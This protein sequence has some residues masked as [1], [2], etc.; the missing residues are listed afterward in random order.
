MSSTKNLIHSGSVSL[1]L[2]LLSIVVQ[3]VSITVLARILTPEEYGLAAVA[4][5]LP[6]LFV[7]I[8]DMGFS[9][10]IV[11]KDI[12]DDA[13]ISTLFWTGL[14][15]GFLL[16][17]TAA[18]VAWWIADI[19]KNE[20]LYELTLVLSLSGLLTAAVMPQRAL[21]AREMGFISLS[22]V[23]FISNVVAVVGAT[24][25]AYSGAGVW[26]LVFLTMAPLAVQIPAWVWL[27]PWKPVMQ[28]KLAALIDGLSFGGRLSIIAMMSYLI[29]AAPAFFLGKWWG[30]HEAGLFSRAYNL[31]FVPI[32]VLT[33]QLT[34]M[35]FSILPRLNNDSEQFIQKYQDGSRLLALLCLPILSVALVTAPGLIFI[36][37]G[38]QWHEV[39]A[40]FRIL[41]VLLFFNPFAASFSWIFIPRAAMAELFKVTWW[42]W[43][44]TMVL[45][46]AGLLLHPHGVAWGVSVAALLALA[47]LA[48]AA[49]QQVDIA[50]IEMWI[51][52]RSYL[53]AALLSIFVGLVLWPY[54][55]RLGLL[56]ATAFT[57][58][59]QLFVYTGCVLS[60]SESRAFILL[61]ARKLVAKYQTKLS[62]LE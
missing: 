14:L 3:L 49:W 19:F 56:W 35:M 59:S 39:E 25:L 21:L 55:T 58:I 20:Q 26:A 40:Y 1:L 32:S 60:F 13:M 47:P 29:Q 24:I 5:A 45:A 44:G 23:G 8:T 34:L 46:G 17:G 36:I 22:L 37:L 28:F 7:L 61:V 62:V 38:P 43:G 10:R 53:C 15:L 51:V 2:R 27:R 33:G 42:Y 48:R 16:I 31:L 6:G 41:S 9:Q 4:R 30:I 52:L 57:A 18:P 11:Q 50:S 54:L 12:L